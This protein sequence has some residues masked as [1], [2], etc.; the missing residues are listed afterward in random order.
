MSPIARIIIVLALLAIIGMS[1]RPAP[2]DLS[3]L[4]SSTTTCIGRNN[5]ESLLLPSACI[6]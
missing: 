2:V 4:S 6:Q 5:A 3:S 1:V